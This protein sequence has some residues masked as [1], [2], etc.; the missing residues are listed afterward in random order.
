MNWKWITSSHSISDIRDWSAGQRS[1]VLA[2]L[3]K[4]SAQYRQKP[5]PTQLNGNG[6][7]CALTTGP[8]KRALGLS[9]GR[10]SAWLA[11]YVD[12]R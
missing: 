11:V 5:T 9:G 4:L 2:A 6:K 8:V 7:V 12:G 10:D 1:I 3:A